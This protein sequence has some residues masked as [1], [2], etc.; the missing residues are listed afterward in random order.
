MG[1]YDHMR[2]LILCQFK[3]VVLHLTLLDTLVKDNV[4]I[5]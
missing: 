1:V 4:K 2:A 3:E 5:V